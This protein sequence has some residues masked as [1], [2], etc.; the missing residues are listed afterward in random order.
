MCTANMLFAPEFITS[1]RSMWVRP[2]PDLDWGA[3]L[4]RR[5]LSVGGFPC[6][7]CRQLSPAGAVGGAAMSSHANH[8]AGF[9]SMEAALR[10]IEGLLEKALSA[11]RPDTGLSARLRRDRLQLSHSL[12]DIRSAREV[13]IIRSKR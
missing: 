1:L 3:C 9:E 2:H 12:C 5:A 4:Y 8:A 7:A 13:L 11:S 6:Y 10:R